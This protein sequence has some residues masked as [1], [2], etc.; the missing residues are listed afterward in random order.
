MSR[1]AVIVLVLAAGGLQAVPALAVDPPP[2]ISTHGYRALVGGMHGGH[3]GYSDG[4]PGSTPGTAYAS[5]KGLGNDFYAMSEHSDNA[6]VPVTASE[7]CLGAA[8]ATCVAADPDR[9]ANALRKWDATAEYASEATSPTFTGIRGFEWTSDRFG[10]L[11]VY[12]SQNDTNAKV[13]GGYATME[14]FWEWF[15]RR[16]ALGG[17]SDGLGTFNHPGDK[18]LSDDDPALN[19]NDFAYVPEADDRM[20]GIEVYNDDQD[21]YGDEYVRALDKGWH[22]GAVG[23]ED[24]GHRPGDDWGGPSWAKTV[25]LAERNDA[26]SIRAAMLARRFYAVRTPGTALDF[27]VDGAVM[28]SRLARQPGTALALAATVSDASVALEVVTSGGAVVATG[29]GSLAATVP[30]PAGGGWYFLRASNEAGQPIGYSSPVWVTPGAPAGVGEWLAGDLHVHT[31]YSGDAYCGPDD[32]NTGPEEFW[33]L[34][35]SVDERFTEGSAKGLDYLAIT[36]HN[37]VRS[38]SDPAFGGRGVIG[39]PGYENSLRGHAQM[40]GATRLFDKGDASATAVNAMADALRAEGGV[41]Q[42]N[43]PAD[44]LEPP[45]YSG[46]DD[47]SGLGWGYGFD[48]RPDTIEVWN[49]GH[50]LQPPAPAGNSNDDSERYWECWL[51]RGARVGATG[52]SDSHWLSTAAIQGPGNPTTWVFARERSA[53]GVL[54]ALREGRTSVSFQPPTLG[55]ARLSLEADA[56]RD[57]VFE[58]IVGDTVPPGTPLRVRASGLLGQ[59]YVTVRGNGATVLDRALL[60]PAGDVRLTAPDGPG[61][62]RASLL[63]PDTTEER[64]AACDPVVGGSTTYCRNRLVQVALTSAIYLG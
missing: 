9:P 61:W 41:F 28:G 60:A 29:T 30:A 38:A 25:V 21:N 37:D 11:N 19:W 48:V 59:G 6:D 2:A 63:L 16:P 3:S 20:V 35:G 32:D 10:H 4:V 23:A 34:S 62:V 1:R 8:V 57:G 33:T 12:F 49:I 58:A 24:I 45:F 36:D 54:E 22:V 5:A 55:A 44:R 56:D 40:L 46:C 43:H 64:T 18:S 39:V 42:A 7:Q 52:G 50:L 47:S 15:S 27:T 14:T 31:C 26:A 51:D 53:A 13:D 17:G